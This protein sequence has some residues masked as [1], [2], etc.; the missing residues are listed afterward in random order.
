[1]RLLVLWNGDLIDYAL[2]DIGHASKASCLFAAKFM[3]CA[4]ALHVTVLRVT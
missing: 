1:M 4:L 2:Q 3:P